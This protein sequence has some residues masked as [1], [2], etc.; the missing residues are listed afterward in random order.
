[1]G[2]WYDGSFAFCTGSNEQ[3]QR[4]LDPNQRSTAAGLLDGAAGVALV[5]LA[6]ATDVDPSWD[7]L[8]LLCD[9]EGEGFRPEL[10][11]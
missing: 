8:F 2:V 3:K 10:S 6:V 11:T 5:L 7:R 9:I 4:N 1:M